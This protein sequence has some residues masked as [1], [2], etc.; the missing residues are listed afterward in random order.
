MTETV[1]SRLNRREF[2][3]GTL[4]GALLAAGSTAPWRRHR[5]SPGF[6]AG[7]MRDPVRR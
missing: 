3:Q 5:A 1:S 7:S 6:S 4:S 2:V